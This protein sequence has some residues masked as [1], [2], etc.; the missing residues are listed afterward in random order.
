VNTLGINADAKNVLKMS[1]EIAVILVDQKAVKFN[2]DD[3]FTYSSGIKSPIY[4]DC[5]VLIS[6]TMKRRII[7]K[8]LQEMTSKKS[9]PDVVC[10]TASAGIPWA[11]WVAQALNKPLIY[12]RKKPKGHGL[13]KQIEG[14]LEEGQNVVLVEDLVSTG[15]SALNAVETVTE[16][17]GDV[18]DVCSIF[19]YGF[20]DTMKKFREKNLGLN[21]ATNLDE[22]LDYAR[23]AGRLSQDEIDEIKD[24]RSN[25]GGWLK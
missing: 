5:R 15:E 17:Q 16:N 10:G 8:R 11:A 21:S 19:T 3:P 14:R 24:W 1:K 23:T 20:P 4:T 25:P 18:T 9:I 6:D 7:S 22:V 12:A 2:I 13:E